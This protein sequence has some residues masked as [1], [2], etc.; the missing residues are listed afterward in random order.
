M[1]AW[2]WVSVLSGVWLE[3][4]ELFLRS[5]RVS[6]TYAVWFKLDI[7]HTHTLTYIRSAS[8]SSFKPT[9][10]ESMGVPLCCRASEG[11]F[12]TVVLF[13]WASFLIQCY[14]WI[15][16]AE[17]SCSHLWKG[18]RSV[19]R[20]LIR[21]APN[22]PRFATPLS[23]RLERSDRNLWIRASRG[24][25]FVTCAPRGR[26]LRLIRGERTDLPALRLHQEFRNEGTDALRILRK[27]PLR[28]EMV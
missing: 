26:T 27:Y 19:W 16:A 8:K 6:H 22:R 20:V 10:L 24:R 28:C 9:A 25:D 7:T 17:R 2:E 18:G 3:G 12:G 1:C 5:L 11:I 15:N 14:I 21:L 4:S 13:P 23:L